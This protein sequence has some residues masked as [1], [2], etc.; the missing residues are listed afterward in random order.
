[1][2]RPSKKAK[3]TSASS[4]NDQLDRLD[5]FLFDPGENVI[6]GK[7]SGAVNFRQA[8]QKSPDRPQVAS[9]RA[10]SAPVTK[11]QNISTPSPHLTDLSHSDRQR[12]IAARGLDRLAQPQQR[13]WH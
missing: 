13:Q 8:D 10:N 7:Q 9:H 4:L 2:P 3:K 1:M 6:S 5:D 11:V 12:R